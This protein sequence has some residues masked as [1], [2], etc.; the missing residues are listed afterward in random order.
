MEKGNS[1]IKIFITFTLATLTA[2]LITVAIYLGAFK[3]VE[4]VESSFPETHLFYKLHIGPYHKIVKTLNEVEKWAKENN[5]TFFDIGVSQLYDNEQI[6]P[7]ASLINFKEQF[8]AKTM[9]RKVMKL[10]L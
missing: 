2:F 3:E 5:L 7:H 4:L 10:K 8:G 6:I 9:I 1:M